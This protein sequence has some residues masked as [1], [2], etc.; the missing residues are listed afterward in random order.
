MLHRSTVDMLMNAFG[1]HVFLQRFLSFVINALIE[2]LGP[3]ASNRG[4]SRKIAISM[5]TLPMESI[6]TKAPDDP[7]ATLHPKMTP[8]FA[9]SL[10]LS[11]GT[12]VYGMGGMDSSGSDQDNYSTDEELDDNGMDE[13]EA[14]ILAKTMSLTANESDS[15]LFPPGLADIVEEEDAFLNESGSSPAAAVA[16]AVTGGSR[17]WP[18]VGGGGRARSPHPKESGGIGAHVERS[19]RL[20]AEQQRTATTASSEQQAGGGGAATSGLSEP[21]FSLSSQSYSGSSVFDSVTSSTSTAST[22]APTSVADLP[23]SLSRSL[24]MLQRRASLRNSLGGQAAGME[25]PAGLT[26]EEEGEE[27]E[28]EGEGE[29]EEGET[30]GDDA[31]AK[32]LESES[33]CSVSSP[34]GHAI[35]SHIARI[36]MDCVCWLSRRLGP[37][38]AT[39]YITKPLMENLH[40]CFTAIVA[41]N[42]REA[43]AVKCLTAIAKHYGEA[44]V[45]KL[46]LPQAEEL[47]SERKKQK[48]NCHF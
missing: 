5:M 19:G 4:F 18:E 40:R 25:Y 31:D 47:V 38:L 29:G 11:E 30:T 22:A 27:G 33:T 3:S 24:Q 39:Q 41:T 6:R 8:D 9:F 17:D 13:P 15:R 7:V 45:L 32:T 2:P 1:L 48:T 21:H 34:H 35:H 23:Y 37:I 20:E 44:V 42:G 43:M 16:A 46:Y 28:E 10:N 14:S 12:G 36:A 26:E